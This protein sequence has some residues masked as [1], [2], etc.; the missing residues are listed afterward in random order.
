M[1]GVKNLGYTIAEQI[2]GCDLTFLVSTMRDFLRGVSYFAV[3]Q[4]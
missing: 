1:A 4:G 2:T 3:E